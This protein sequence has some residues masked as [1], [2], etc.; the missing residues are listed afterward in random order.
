MTL[1]SS[2]LC[3]S[4]KVFLVAYSSSLSVKSK[5]GDKRKLKFNNGES[6]SIIF[7]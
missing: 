2:K 3:G 4:V 7:K 1:I 6:F 5:K